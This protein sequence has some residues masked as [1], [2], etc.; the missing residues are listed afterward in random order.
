MIETLLTNSSFSK[1]D[2]KS[3]LIR[4][5]RYQGDLK[6]IYRTGATVFAFSKILYN[7]SKTHAVLII[8]HICFMKYGSGWRVFLKKEDDQWIV[9]DYQE[10]WV[11]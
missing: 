4:V 8:D 3:K 2:F 1:S 5:E 6:S 11:E 10:T 7:E 9:T